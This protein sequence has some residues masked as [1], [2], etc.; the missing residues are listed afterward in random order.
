VV[1]GTIAS[2][3]DAVDYLTWTFLFRRWVPAPNRTATPTPR[4]VM[5]LFDMH[6]N[7]NPH[8]SRLGYAVLVG[9]PTN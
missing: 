7:L 3:A 1:A 8:I 2:A 4:R 5:A 6:V 9:L